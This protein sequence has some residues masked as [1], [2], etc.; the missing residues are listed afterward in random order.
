M[1]YRG[2][3][4]TYTALRKGAGMLTC[5][6]SMVEVLFG[7]SIVGLLVVVISHSLSLYFTASSEA[8]T[9]TQALYLA[10][11]GQ[12]ILRY[13]RDADWTDISSLTND[14]PYYLNVTDTTLA[15]TS[16]PEV[17]DGTFLR[18]FEVSEVRRD[19]STDDIVTSGG[20]VDSDARY[21]TFSV[22]W[23]NA[24]VTVPALLTNIHGI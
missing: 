4:N 10:E 8:L 16:T 18:R 12:E 5:G 21:V 20:S 14:T 3:T 19:S 11:E 15:I 2:V 23:N 22:G 24:T 1:Y 9:R 6:V 7:V 13:L 17:V